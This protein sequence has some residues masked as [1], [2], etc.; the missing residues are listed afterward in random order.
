MNI[1]TKENSTVNIQRETLT[2]LAGHLECNLNFRVMYY[3]EARTLMVQ[4]WDDNARFNEHFMIKV[5][6]TGSYCDDTNRL[7]QWLIANIPSASD[8]ESLY[9][10]TT[11]MLQGLH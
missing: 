5:K 10:W 9:Y 2:H 7:T 6:Q 8:Q 11:T 1:V 3:T 4:V